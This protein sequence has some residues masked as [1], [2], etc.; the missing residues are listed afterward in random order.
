MLLWM[1]KGT[2]L[3]IYKSENIFLILN[4]RVPIVVINYF[5]LFNDRAHQ[6]TIDPT[7]TYEMVFIFKYVLRA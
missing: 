5:S 2:Y 7:K 6:F 3:L 1:F 4:F